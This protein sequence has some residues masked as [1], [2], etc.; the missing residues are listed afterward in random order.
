MYI[1]IVF[2]G[3]N[4]FDSIIF[5]LLP[6]KPLSLSFKQFYIDLIGLHRLKVYNINSI[7]IS[8][9]WFKTHETSHGVL[10]SFSTILFYESILEFDLSTFKYLF[11]I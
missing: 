11:N 1:E 8:G 9:I 3:M 5:Y 4:V 2:E 7:I 10:L 6:L